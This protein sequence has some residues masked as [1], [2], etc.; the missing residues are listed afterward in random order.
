MTL[1]VIDEEKEQS[2]NEWLTRGHWHLD[3][4]VD[5]LW[6]E[7]RQLRAGLTLSAAASNGNEKLREGLN[8]MPDLSRVT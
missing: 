4:N 8:E 3:V 2:C 7:P 6:R 1:H 5:R